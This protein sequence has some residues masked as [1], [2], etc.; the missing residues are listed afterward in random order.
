M[1]SQARITEGNAGTLALSA[2]A[3]GSQELPLPSREMV[4][5]LVIAGALIWS[6][7]AAG[8]AGFGAQAA[9]APA[10]SRRISARF[11]AALAALGFSLTS[12]VTGDLCPLLVAWAVA[13]SGTAV[14]GC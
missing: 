11:A 7:P 3:A 2:N 10:P 4:L 8:A 1:Y 14:A 6:P 9:T 5:A 13:S 12:A